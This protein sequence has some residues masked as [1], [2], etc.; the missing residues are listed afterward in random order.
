[1]GQQA[2]FFSETNEQRECFAYMI[3]MEKGGGGG[4]GAGNEVSRKSVTF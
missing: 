4:G 1:M 3:R 2:F